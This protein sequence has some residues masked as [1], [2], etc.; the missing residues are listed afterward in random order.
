[1]S[2]VNQGVASWLEQQVQLALYAPD[3]YESHGRRGRQP[4]R[5]V[6]NHEVKQM[7]KKNIERNNN[8]AL[9]M[10]SMI[11]LDISSVKSY[12]EVLFPSFKRNYILR[13]DELEISYDWIINESISK[14]LCSQGL[15]VDKHIRHDIYKCIYDEIGVL[16]EKNIRE[17]ID[18]QGYGFIFGTKVKTM[19]CGPN[20]IL[21][22]SNNG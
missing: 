19:V 20:L 13:D 8:E 9:N 15:V 16:V 22:R 12:Y 6:V 2:D 17:I 3:D 7:H 14:M 21:A 4:Y 1:M 10:Y 11:V 5:H 18:R